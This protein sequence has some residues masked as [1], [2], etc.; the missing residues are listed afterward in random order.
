M[1]WDD[2]G[3]CDAESRPTQFAV[4]ERIDDRPVTATFA[5]LP[6]LY[7]DLVPSP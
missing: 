7:D 6:E 5:H 4:I 3:G 1:N 2:F